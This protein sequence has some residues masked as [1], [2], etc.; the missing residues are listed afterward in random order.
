MV[1]VY[2][3]SDRESD[4][5]ISDYYVRIYLGEKYTSSQIRYVYI[6]V[7]GTL[8]HIGAAGSEVPKFFYV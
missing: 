4:E 3:S 8:T 2:A 5:G 7:I 1:H 6:C